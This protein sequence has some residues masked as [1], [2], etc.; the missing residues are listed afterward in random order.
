[1]RTARSLL[2]RIVVATCLCAPAPALALCVGENLFDA[3]APSVQTELR[4]RAAEAPFAEGLYWR[5]ERGDARITLIGTFHFDDPRHVE[6]LAALAPALAEARALLVEA[7]P[8]EEAALQ[9]AMV[10]RLDLFFVPNGPTLPERLS[11][12]D[13]QRLSDAMRIRG[14]P[15]FFAAKFKPW[16]AAMTLS[17][18]PCALGE[19]AAG[20]KGLD[21]QLIAAADARGLPVRALEPF[22]AALTLFD[23]VSETDQLDLIRAALL[24]ASAA[25]DYTATLAGA[26]FAEETR[27]IWEFTR[28]DA[29]ANSGLDAEVVDAQLRLGEEY[30][31]ERRNRAWL[32]PILAEAAEGPVLV[33]IGALH[34]PGQG[35]LL[36][37]LQAE[38]FRLTRLALPR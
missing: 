6:T 13:W 11:A 25:D 7:G 37:L 28:H 8:A 33:A 9:A 4:A 3:L 14:V 29:L 38:G 35:G 27:L 23:L 26:Y 36:A 2:C 21:G 17:L 20:Q 15:A 31:L 32:A 5:A 16:Y 22:D 24:T 30:L 19:V 34:L 12:S 10:E 18:S 1:M